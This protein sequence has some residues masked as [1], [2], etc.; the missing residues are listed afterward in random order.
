M[1]R[2]IYIYLFQQSDNGAM[3]MLET[4]YS[5]TVEDQIKTYLHGANSIPCFLASISL[6]LLNK[7][8]ILT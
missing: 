6:E 4:P 8:T 3:Q 7:Q 2:S 5:A 1:Y